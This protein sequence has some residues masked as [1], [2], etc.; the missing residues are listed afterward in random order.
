VS[1][2]TAYEM[3]PICGLPPITSDAEQKCSPLSGCAAW[4]TQ[5]VWDRETRRWQPTDP[6]GFALDGTYIGPVIDRG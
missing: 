4:S 1:A 6:D 3:C 5:A 2:K